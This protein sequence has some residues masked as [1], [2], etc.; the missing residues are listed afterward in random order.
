MSLELQWYV[1]IPGRDLSIP[2]PGEWCWVDIEPGCFQ[3]AQQVR[4]QGT[5]NTTAGLPTGIYCGRYTLPAVFGD[6][7]ELA[8]FGLPLWHAAYEPP[9]YQSFIPYNGWDKPALWQW[10]SAG[11]IT[12]F[13]QHQNRIIVNCDMNITPDGRWFLDLS[14]Y[15]EQLVSGG[16]FTQRE[17]DFIKHTFAGVVIGLQN[18]AIAR[19]LKGLLS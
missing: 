13:D 15:S 19:Q 7:T 18:A 9:D 8:D 5:A 12:G 10:S 11:F 3:D 17:A 1:D 2:N 14:N 6:S 4:D 16:P